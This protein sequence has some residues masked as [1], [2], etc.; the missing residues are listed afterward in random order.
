MLYSTNVRTLDIQNG[1]SYKRGY[2]KFKTFDVIVV[3]SAVDLHHVDKAP[4]LVSGR[5]NDA[6]PALAPTS[7]SWLI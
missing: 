1:K 2:E 7:R 6:A 4:D 3:F 5:Q